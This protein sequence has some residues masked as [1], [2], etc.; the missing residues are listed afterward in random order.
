[1]TDKQIKRWST[2]KTR[3]IQ[4]F[5]DADDYRELIRLNHLVLE[6]AGK[7]HN[8]NMLLNKNGELIK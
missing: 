3:Y 8:E 1:M 5:F 7:I 2:L 4:G 6:V